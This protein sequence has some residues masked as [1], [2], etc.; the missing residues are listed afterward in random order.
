MISLYIEALVPS[1]HKF[2]KTSS[3]KFFGLLLE[4][5]SDFPFHH[6]HDEGHDVLARIVTG[7]ESWVHHY[8]PETKRVSMQWKHPASPAKI[9]LSDTILQE[10]DTHSRLGS[11]RHT[12]HRIP[13]SRT[14]RKCRLLLLTFSGN[15]G[16]PFNGSDQDSPDQGSH[17]L[18]LTAAQRIVCCWFSG[19]CEMMG[20]VPQCTGR[21]C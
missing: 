17:R 5:G 7:D 10:S 8:Q 9:N 21:L 11:R 2:L 15:I 14:N 6:Y 3:I 18:V 12:A 20:Q 1:F 13:P 16:R 4:P 19:A